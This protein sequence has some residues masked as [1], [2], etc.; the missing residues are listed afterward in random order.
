[1]PDRSL[2]VLIE[3]TINWAKV[4]GELCRPALVVGLFYSHPDVENLPREGLELW[5]KAIQ[6]SVQRASRALAS[7][8]CNAFRTRRAALV[9]LE[10]VAR[11][12]AALKRAVS[13][14]TEN[15]NNT[16]HAQEQAADARADLA[17]LSRLD[18]IRFLARLRESVIAEAK[19]P[20]EDLQEAG[21]A[22]ANLESDAREDSHQ[23]GLEGGR[24][25]WWRNVRYKIPKGTVYRFL[26]FMWDK[27]CASYSF[28]CRL[29]SFR[30]FSVRHEIFIPASG[31]GT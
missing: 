7:I 16:E 5:S 11:F 12:A 31:G 1:V 8:P 9:A 10:K 22:I 4:H 18:V 29:Y 17:A 6:V 23:D 25:L 24:W 13:C 2:D 27:D 19:H 15:A 14:S 28:H 3:A 20:L 21:N 26:Q 30:F